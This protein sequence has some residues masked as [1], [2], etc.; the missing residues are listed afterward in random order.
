MPDPTKQSVSASQA[1]ALFVFKR[2]GNQHIACVPLVLRFEE[3]TIPEP[4]SGCLLWLG[5]LTPEGYGKIYDGGRM[6]FA[7]IVAYELNVGRVPQGKELDH[8]CRVR[9]C[10]N[11][12]H[13]EPVT[14][15]VNAQRGWDARGKKRECRRGHLLT[16]ETVWLDRRGNRHCRRCRNIR[17]AAWKARR[18]A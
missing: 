14:Q 11:W 9:C 5:A 6:R 15:A 7:H 2:S 10:V 3:K 12:L 16:A 8:K 1:A 18:H 17:I 13:L 4:N